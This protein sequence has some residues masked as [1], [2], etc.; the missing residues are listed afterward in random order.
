MASHDRS[1]PFVLFLVHLFPLFTTT[2]LLHSLKVNPPSPVRFA[3][4]LYLL[5][6]LFLIGYSPCIFKR[7]VVTLS[8][9]ILIALVEL[10]FLFE[11]YRYVGIGGDA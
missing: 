7:H 6:L 8:I 10:N 5:F 9:I 3:I 11:R 1:V 4:Y 2:S